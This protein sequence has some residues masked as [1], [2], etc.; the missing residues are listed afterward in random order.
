M[1][2]LTIYTAIFGKYDQFEPPVSCVAAGARFVLFTDDPSNAVPREC[3]SMVVVDIPMM[4]SRL[5][6]RFVKTL[7]HVWLPDADATLWMDGSMKITRPDLMMEALTRMPGEIAAPLSRFRDCIYQEAAECLKLNLDSLETIKSQVDR[8]K[9]EWYPAQ[10][11][12]HETGLM[13]RKNT[14]RIRALCDRWWME[15][16]RGS[17]R[18]QLSFD[19]VAHKEGVPVQALPRVDSLPWIRKC[20]HLVKRTS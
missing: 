6:S 15:I 20:D 7:P 13:F 16:S 5:R 3:G 4:P 17:I 14:P 10:N 1:R 12:L 19:Y 9:T 18:D 11:G 8:Y 2:K